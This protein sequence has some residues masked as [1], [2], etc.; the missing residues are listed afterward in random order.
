MY[1]TERGYGAGANDGATTG[2]MGPSK[3]GCANKR[4]NFR[5]DMTS[6]FNICTP[7]RF[8]RIYQQVYNDV[9]FNK[10]RL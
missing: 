8:L 9:F 2:S 5:N 6:M 7:K 4:R 1:I 10:V 3:A